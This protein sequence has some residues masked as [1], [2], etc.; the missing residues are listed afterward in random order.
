MVCDGWKTSSIWDQSDM[1][2][3]ASMRTPVSNA[4]TSASEDEWEIADCFL[5]SHARGT[6]VCEPSR[7]KMPPDVDLLSLRSPA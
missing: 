4:M 6:N 3:K 7:H 5:H 2:G 1:H